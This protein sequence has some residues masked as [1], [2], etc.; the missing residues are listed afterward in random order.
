MFGQTY[1]HSLIRKYVI[2]VGTLFNDIHITRTNSSGDTTALLNAIGANV[3]KETPDLSNRTKNLRNRLF[4]LWTGIEKSF[5]S[6]SFTFV[7]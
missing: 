2:L 4:V 1:Y 7:L 6:K 5:S 3:L